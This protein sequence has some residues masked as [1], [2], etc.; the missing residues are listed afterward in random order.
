MMSCIQACKR[1]E[2][3]LS[4]R[5]AQTL[6]WNKIEQLDSICLNLSP[7]KMFCLILIFVLFFKHFKTYCITTSVK[8]PSKLRKSQIA[9][10]IKQA[11]C[12]RGLVKQGSILVTY[13]MKLLNLN[14]NLNLNSK[15]QSLAKVGA[16]FLKQT[17]LQ[18]TWENRILKLSGVRQQKQ[19]L[20]DP[21]GL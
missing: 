6:S 3:Y 9:A 19:G 17:A 15:L 12:W 14:S 13:H 5:S 2:E 16:L 1:Q 20:W 8:D 4:L 21:T 7:R 18:I 11:A 10:C